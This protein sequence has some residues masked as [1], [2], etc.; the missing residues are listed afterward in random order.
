MKLNLGPLPERYTGLASVSTRN[1]SFYTQLWVS[2][3]KCPRGSQ[4]DQVLH[5]NSENR[6]S[7]IFHTPTTALQRLTTYTCF[8][9]NQIWSKHDATDRKFGH[10]VVIVT[11][12]L[13]SVMGHLEVA[14]RT[15]T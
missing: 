11:V 9:Y 4:I 7:I 13:L 15:M 12:I 5:E 10:T 1:F 6:K 2:N 8:D 3:V 14:L